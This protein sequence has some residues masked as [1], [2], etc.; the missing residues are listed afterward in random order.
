[1]KKILFTLIG[2][3]LLM[4]CSQKAGETNQYSA[5]PV[6][7]S[8]VQITD[9]FWSK[10]IETNR[11]VTIPYDL[12]KCE[13]TGRIN[14]FA[15]A[16]GLKEGAFEG[17]RY[18][19]SD[20]YKVMEG[21]AYSI[22]SHPDS[23][24]EKYMDDL[25]AL[26]AAAQE[27]DGYLYTQRTIDS[28]KM[29]KNAGPKR[30]SY[31]Q[32]SHELYNVGH[33]Y[34][35]AVA[36]YDATG[37]RNLLDV[38]MKNADFLLTVFGPD[39]N[40][41]VPGHQEI[42]IGL[43]KLYRVTGK[44]AYLDLAK[45]FLDQRGIGDTRELYGDYCQ[46]HI[47]VVEQTEAVG[48]AVRALYMYSGMADVASQTGDSAFVKAID[49]IW[50]NMVA[51]RIYIT[52]GVGARRSGEAFGDDYELPNASAYNET[53]AAIANM[54][55]NHR[56][57]L[58]HE[59]AKYIDVLERTLYNGFLAGVSLEG[60]LFFYP[61]PLESDGVDKFNQGA[62]ERQPWFNCSCCPVNVVRTMP[63][64]PGY[65]YA[66]SKEALFVNLFIGSEAQM[67]VNGIPVRVQQKT[68]YP[69][70]GEVAITIQPE[71]ESEFAVKIRIP[72]WV[73]GRPLPSDL[74]TFLGDNPD[75]ISLSVNG[76]PVAVKTEKGY[77]SLTR[78]WRAGDV[79][80]L[81]LPMPVR[82]V[83]ANENVAADLQKIA[84][85]RGPVVYC[86]EGMDN[87]DNVLDMRL[88]DD[89]RL[90]TRFR[91]DK[92]GGIVELTGAAS[93]IRGKS[94]K[95]TAIPYYAWNHRGA[96]EMTVWIHRK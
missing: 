84:L 88:A 76:E 42:E 19:D 33:M 35:A 74:Y 20:V 65:I 7:F 29:E 46:D 56:L 47:P 43:V 93:T 54:M 66:Q 28:T 27:N 45:F 36:W 77:V 82:R 95:L 92:L 48:H 71:K 23:A 30:W 18:N 39:K 81:N 61:N 68:E 24:L 75:K 57:F 5:Q 58:L 91:G 72:G 2:C 60:N 3:T 21:I 85:E 89:T 53:C 13:E 32:H 94:K 38:A 31:L 34:E 51:R 15:V 11:T 16:G 4:Q 90:Q 44:K 67:P 62:A 41:G 87:R 22:S 40:H 55:W 52:G 9:D 8:E 86:I 78:K 12:Q 79:V 63:A 70:N 69:W 6:L 80:N 96:N 49:R 37:K 17:I 50:D 73:Q 25:I 59:D 83:L 1:M 10:R 14:N 26:I 64:L